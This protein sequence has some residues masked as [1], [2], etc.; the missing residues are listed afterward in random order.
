[1]RARQRWQRT[2]PATVVGEGRLRAVRARGQG[3]GGREREGGNG[4]KNR[5]LFLLGLK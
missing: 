1:M 5:A 4:L 3:E 2:A